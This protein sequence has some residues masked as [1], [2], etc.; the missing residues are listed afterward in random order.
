MKKALQLQALFIL[1]ILFFITSCGSNSDEAS[2]K[3]ESLE[4]KVELTK[5]VG[6]NESVIYS[7]DG[8]CDSFIKGIDFSSLCVT[9]EAELAYEIENSSDIRCQ[10]RILKENWQEETHFVI[11]WKD[12]AS[13]DAEKIEMDQLLTTVAFQKTGARLYPETKKINDLGDDAY[14][15]YEEQDGSQEKHLAIILNNVSINISTNWIDENCLSTDAELL[16]LGRLII[17]KIKK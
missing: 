12:Y 16:K 4:G 14:I 1:S 2:S 7:R 11:T 3:S 17:D 10:Y 15:G 8:D 9:E 6:K 13:Y 5:E